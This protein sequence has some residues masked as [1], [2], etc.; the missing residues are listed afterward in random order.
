MPRK[1]H[2]FVVFLFVVGGAEIGHH[3][4]TNKSVKIFV[5]KRAG[6]IER[7][8]KTTNKSVAR[9]TEGRDNPTPDLLLRLFFGP[10]LG[11]LHEDEVNHCLMGFYVRVDFK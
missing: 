1:R 5:V 6:E 2:L 3:G 9:K 4:T 11:E 8:E 10:E 7:R